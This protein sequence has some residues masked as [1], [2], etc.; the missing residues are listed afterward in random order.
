LIAAV[1]RRLDLRQ[2]PVALAGGVIGA[3]QQLQQ[4]VVAQAGV[5]LGPLRYVADP[6]HGALVLAQR[7]LI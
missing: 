1:T 5:A 6:A 7:L 3:S 4:A 2:P